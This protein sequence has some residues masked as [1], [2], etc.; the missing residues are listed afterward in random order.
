MAKVMVRPVLCMSC[1][2]ITD[3]TLFLKKQ[4]TGWVSH[5]A[6]CLVC[7]HDNEYCIPE[8]DWRALLKGNYY[9]R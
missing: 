9:E 3:C 1:R 6:K 7:G 4:Y 8:R 2:Q 5:I